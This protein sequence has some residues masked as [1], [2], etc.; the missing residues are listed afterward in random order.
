MPLPRRS[1]LRAS[2][3]CIGLPLLDAMLPI[4]FGAEAKA[5]AMRARR[6]VFINRP[7]GLH[8]PFMT[9]LE[10]GRDYVATRYLKLLEEHRRDFTFFS[11]VSHLGYTGHGSGAGL[12]TGIPAHNMRST[13]D[14]RNTI[15]LD[16][17]A[18]S[19][20]GGETRYASL[21]LGGGD[22]SWNAKGV[23]VPSE[24][25]NSVVFQQLF[26]EGTA[27]EKAK[28]MQRIAGGRSILDGVRDQA[29]QLSTSVGAADRARLELLLSSIREAEQ[30]LQQDEAWVNKPK[31]RV[32]VKPYGDLA[33]DKM[34]ERER[35][36]YELVHLALQTDVTR[37]VTLHL[38]SHSNV[39]VDGTQIGHHD[40]SHHGRDETKIE[41]LARIEEAEL[42]LF[43]DF[44]GKLRQT[45][46]GGRS[47]LT[48][49]TVF[50]ASN[51]SNASAHTCDNLPIILA[52]GGYRHGGH[53]AFDRRNNTPLSNLLLRVAQHHGLEID[54]FGSST[55]VLSEV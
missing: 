48:G 29:K 32:E 19:K 10:S 55:G 20:L 31:P 37:I 47:L 9:P 13:N 5:E 34:L 40:M 53:L 21:P 36:W 43:N 1:F 38:H 25:R 45:D 54:R 11:G 46:D 8:M 41:Q 51:L 12:L 24:S 4:G 17:L 42:R 39:D 18:A 50:F 35:R 23:R 26:I 16:Q 28:E 27:E 49:S 30:R 22:L 44:L 14:I 33:A 3:V 15:S 7:L 2:G 52:G 6:M